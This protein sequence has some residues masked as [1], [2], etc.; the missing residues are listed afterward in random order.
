MRTPKTAGKRL[1][2]ALNAAIPDGSE[3][4]EAEQVTLG[5]LEDAADRVAVLKRLFDAEVCKPEVST[6]RVTELTAEL[7]QH[8]VN[9]QKW[10]AGFDLDMARVKSTRHQHAANV[11][12]LNRA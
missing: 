7:R 1:I 2:S 3:W 12:W 4:T 9:I 5:L 11:R 8:E 6:R 10:V